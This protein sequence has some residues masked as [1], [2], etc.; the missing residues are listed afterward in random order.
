[1]V[2]GLGPFEQ[3]ELDET[4]NAMKL[5]NSQL[6]HTFSKAPSAP[7]FTRNNSWR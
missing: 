5:Y 1:M 7:F 4:W 2:F 3:V 6:I